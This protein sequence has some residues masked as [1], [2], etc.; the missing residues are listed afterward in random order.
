M[1]PFSPH[2]TYYKYHSKALKREKTTKAFLKEKSFAVFSSVS[3]PFSG[4]T[5]NMS[6]VYS[7][8]A[9]ILNFSHQDPSIPTTPLFKD[10]L[11]YVP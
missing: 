5:T 2:L 4:M 6:L 8:I 10:L 7:Q 1:N 9:T 11:L 3:I